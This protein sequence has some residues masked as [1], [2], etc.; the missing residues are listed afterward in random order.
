MV[1]RDS[2]AVACNHNLRVV[3]DKDKQS[4]TTRRGTR[5]DGRQD[6]INANHFENRIRKDHSLYSG[7]THFKLR[8]DSVLKGH[9]FSRAVSK[10]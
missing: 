8:D 3:A 10:S 9:G 1:H 7:Q 4:R 2:P 5:E 6:S